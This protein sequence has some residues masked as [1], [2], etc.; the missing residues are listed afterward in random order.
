MCSKAVSVKRALVALCGLGVLCASIA[1]ALSCDSEN[2]C[3]SGQF[4][5]ETCG[6]CFV[7]DEQAD[8]D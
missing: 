1:V 5:C 6:C 7:E 8:P 3:P 4:C 2:P